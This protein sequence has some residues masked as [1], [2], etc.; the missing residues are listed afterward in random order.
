MCQTGLV[1]YGQVVEYAALYI[2]QHD[3]ININ[4]PE[5]LLRF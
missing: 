4:L 1:C 5:T 2:V 3:E